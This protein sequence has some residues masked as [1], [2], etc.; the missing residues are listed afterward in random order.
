[1]DDNLHI[2]GALAGGR[3]ARGPKNAR[4]EWAAGGGPRAR[5][6]L[7]AGIGRPAGQPTIP[8]GRAPPDRNRTR[9]KHVAV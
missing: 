7:A 9:K 4:T 6:H 1:M 8:V 5:I 2:R 3:P